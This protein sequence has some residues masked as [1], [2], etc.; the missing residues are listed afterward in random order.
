MIVFLS[1]FLF[2]SPIF[3]MNRLSRLSRFVQQ[4]RNSK[5]LYANFLYDNNKLCDLLNVEKDCKKMVPIDNF[6]S[7]A[8]KSYFLQNKFSKLYKH[9][10]KNFMPKHLKDWEEKNEIVYAGSDNTELV[11]YLIIFYL[12]FKKL[13]KDWKIEVTRRK[14]MF[15]HDVSSKYSV[16]EKS[17]R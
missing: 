10:A 11:L 2:C 5:P 6:Y 3:A 14:I 15:G 7:N 16:L 17:K 13:F 4:Y 9:N 1:L 12:L 8:Y